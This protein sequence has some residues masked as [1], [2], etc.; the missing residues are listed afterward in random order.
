MLRLGDA[1]DL[2]DSNLNTV[3]NLTLSLGSTIV[4]PPFRYFKTSPEIIRLA[5]TMYVQFPLSLRNVEDLFRYQTE[6]GPAAQRLLRVELAR[7]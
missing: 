1:S 7:R 4:E 6:A 5:E 3:V 2:A